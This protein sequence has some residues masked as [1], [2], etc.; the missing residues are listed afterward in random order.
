MEIEKKYLIKS[1]PPRFDSFESAD[2]SQSYILIDK[3]NGYEKRVRRITKG[4]ITMFFLTEK[5]G[6]GLV[7]EEI[8]KEIDLAEYDSL[9]KK[10]VTDELKKTRYFIPLSDSLTAELDVYGGSLSGLCTAEVEFPTEEDAAAFTPPK[11][12]GEEITEDKRYKNRSLA[13]SGMPKSQ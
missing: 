5:S 8:E 7:R 1:L 3:K 9:I 6:S 10:A 2:V 4:G 11:W 13:V 12:F